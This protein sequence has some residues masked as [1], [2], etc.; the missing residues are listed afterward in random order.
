MAFRRKDSPNDSAVITLKELTGTYK[1]TNFDTKETFENGAD[2]KI[3]LP[4][5][6]SCVIFKYN[7]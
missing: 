3:V 5:K 2:F 4:E 1:F 7:K 6:Y